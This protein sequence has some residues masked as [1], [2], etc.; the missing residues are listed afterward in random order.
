MKDSG[1]GRSQGCVLFQRRLTQL[2]EGLQPAAL[3]SV[4]RLLTRMSELQRQGSAVSDQLWAHLTWMVP[5]FVFLWDKEKYTAVDDGTSHI[6]GDSKL[7]ESLM[8]KPPTGRRKSV[9]QV[10]SAL[11]PSVRQAHCDLYLSMI[12]ETSFWKHLCYIVNVS[13]DAGESSEFDSDLAVHILISATLHTADLFSDDARRDRLLAAW[14]DGGLFELFV[15]L[16]SIC[17]S[18]EV[19]VIGTFFLIGSSMNNTCRKGLL[20]TILIRLFPG[21]MVSCIRNICDVLEDPGYPLVASALRA[22]LPQPRLLRSILDH[23]LRQSTDITHFPQAGEVL[24]L[25]LRYDSTVEG[26]RRWLWMALH[27]L[28]RTTEMSQCQGR[29]CTN[30]GALRCVTC[31][32]K[33]AGRYCGAEC[34]KR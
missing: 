29:G 10:K 24:D 30:R 17:T 25:H 15:K 1:T 34:Q 2:I 33:A 27:I 18:H 5:K 11:A 19:L 23:D 13:H 26:S 12:V 7:E 9:V 3:S 21:S 20:T 4:P 31:K 8:P 22:H 6:L 16:F 28:H 14:L 32:G